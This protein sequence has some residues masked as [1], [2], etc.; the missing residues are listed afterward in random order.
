MPCYNAAVAQ[1]RPRRG[2]DEV[3]RWAA[4]LKS[5]QALGLGVV[6]VQLALVLYE[7]EVLGLH[8]PRC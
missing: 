6:V 5:G 8:A 1:Q 3:E 7:L 4:L 2:R